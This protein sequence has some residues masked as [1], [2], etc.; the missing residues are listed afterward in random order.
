[1]TDPKGRMFISYRR[2]PARN[3]G[4][5]EAQRV[6]DALRDRGVPTWRDLDDHG[7]SPTEDEVVQT[8]NDIGTAGAV[9]LVSPEIATSPMV[10]M[11]E[12]PAMLDRY[13]ELDGF[14]LKPV[15][16]DLDYPD[17]DKVLGRPGAF[18]EL[19]RF[20]ILKLPSETLQP[21]DAKRIA[22]DVVKSRLQAIRAAAPD[23][24]F[25][26]GL[27]SRRTPGVDGYAL[28]HDVT[29]YFDGRFAIDGAYA[30]I[31]SALYDSASA[32]A[33]T[34][35]RIRIAARGNAALP[36]GVLFGALYSPFVFDLVWHQSAPGRPPEDWSL[37][38]GVEDVDLDISVSR[39]DPQ[40]EDLVLALSMNA[41]VEHAAAEYFEAH[42]FIPR[43]TI[44]VGL[45]GGPLQRGQ[46]MSA[47][48]G[49]TV[50]YAAID[51]ARNLKTQLRLKRANLHLFLSCPL[52]L[53]VLIG[54]NLNT[55]ND[56]FLYEHLEGA[57]PVYSEVHRFTP[58]S[59]TFTTT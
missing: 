58:S 42:S 55:F 17:I 10:R 37:K 47:R 54:Q 49:L 22:R 50:T 33:A 12:A 27:F 9:M 4:D 23:A 39:G 19:S 14:L 3:S 5:D 40:S 8:L 1:M 13:K 20:D 57:H 2:S 43:A 31:E 52:G 28:R 32:L 18:Q 29:P 41:N 21:A 46:A 26:V 45:A 24:P 30:K 11:V 25:Q 16:I 44:H 34:G 6:R 35:D 53:A 51:A 7:P 56:C 15:L 38:T 36:L 48:Q 59:L